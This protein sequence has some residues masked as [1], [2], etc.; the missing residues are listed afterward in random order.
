MK[1]KKKKELKKN[2][3]LVVFANYFLK[4]Y[5]GKRIEILL[6]NNFNLVNY[7][8]QT[9]ESVNI[10]EWLEVY[11]LENSDK[12][13]IAFPGSRQIGVTQEYYED[14]LILLTDFFARYGLAVQNSD[15]KNKFLFNTNLKSLIVAYQ[16]EFKKLN[17]NNISETKVDYFEKFDFINACLDSVYSE[18][19]VSNLFYDLFLNGFIKNLIVDKTLLEDSDNEKCTNIVSI[20]MGNSSKNEGSKLFIEGAYYN[21]FIK[22]IEA[23]VKKNELGVCAG[24]MLNYQY[25]SEFCI[26]FNTTLAKLKTAYW[27]EVERCEYLCPTQLTKK[28]QEMAKFLS[29]VY[30]KLLENSINL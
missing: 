8:Q 16:E 28:S 23:F 3:L 26:C 30:I 12:K 15:E 29:N 6:R 4:D 13:A 19:V 27:N 18:D 1:Q 21:C 24:P 9:L 10:T 22:L 25:H 5:L 14:F 7:E 11:V 2:S 20:Y 17:E